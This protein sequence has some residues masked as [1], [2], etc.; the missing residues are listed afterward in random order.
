MYPSHTSHNRAWLWPSDYEMHA[1]QM[2]Q[3]AF[4]PLVLVI[5]KWYRYVHLIE[6]IRTLLYFDDSNNIPVKL[7]I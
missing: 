6:F 2:Q 5:A 7:Q 1:S 3:R 4:Y